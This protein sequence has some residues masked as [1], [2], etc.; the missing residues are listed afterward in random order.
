MWEWVLGSTENY[1]NRWSI[2]RNLLEGDS[3]QMKVT[4]WHFLAR[5]WYNLFKSFLGNVTTRFCILFSLFTVSTT[6]L[7]HRTAERYFDALRSLE[8]DETP[9]FKWVFWKNEIENCIMFSALWPP[10]TSQKIDYNVFMS[11]PP[12][13]IVN[14]LDLLAAKFK[15]IHLCLWIKVP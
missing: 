8:I 9:P 12:R 13:N 6:T 3:E 5:N 15:H 1:K 2:G 4:R 7:K 14:F 10:G 11:I